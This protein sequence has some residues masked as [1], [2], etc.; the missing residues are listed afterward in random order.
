MD[1]IGCK[2]ITLISFWQANGEIRKCQIIY[3]A[4]P[5][6]QSSSCC[7]VAA[8]GMWSCYELRGFYFRLCRFGKMFNAGL[9][10]WIIHKPNMFQTPA[11][12]YVSNRS[13]VHFSSNS[14]TLVLL[15]QEKT[16][17]N[18]VE[19]PL[20]CCIITPSACLL[21]VCVCVCVC[22]CS[23]LIV[24]PF[25][26][27]PVTHSDLTCQWAR[28]LTQLLVEPPLAGVRSLS[29]SLSLSL[30]SLSLFLSPPSL[31]LSLFL[32]LSL[33]FSLF[34]SPPSLSFS[35]LPLALCLSLFLS[36]SVSLSFSLLPRSLSLSSLSLSSSCF[37]PIC[38]LIDS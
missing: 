12:L 13:V 11:W 17:G 29:L 24:C 3:A 10:C 19:S 6:S 26:Q 8:G 28:L 32:S 23:C 16:V 30:S 18:S 36:L 15:K 34:L 27:R 35:L 20:V 22:V 7:S 4:A 25:F 21:P 37:T 2:A 14:L 1:F 38:F 33:C 31:S 5:F 9:D